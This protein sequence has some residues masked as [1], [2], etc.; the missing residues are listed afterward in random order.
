MTKKIL[1]AYAT[2]AGSTSEIAKVIG[3]TL[4]SHGTAVDVLPIKSVTDLT[5][6]QAVVVGSAV[7]YSSLLPEAVKFVEQNRAVLAQ[8]PL[9]IFA[10]HILN[11]GSD[12]ASRQNRSVY[13]DSV[14]KL[15]LPRAEA[16]FAGVGD[17]KKVA[18]FE[19]LL[20]KAIKPPEGDY[21]DWPA[22]R[23]WAESLENVL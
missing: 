12:E 2:R 20:F 10:A 5:G 17:P 19:R 11:M 8:R 16:C 6:Y 1:V 3:E 9:A 22:I 18:L 15:V 13:L 4:A 7:R 21:R 14:R 23:A